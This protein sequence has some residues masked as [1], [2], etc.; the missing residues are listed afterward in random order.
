[1][2]NLLTG[3]TT[4]QSL[5]DLNFSQEFSKQ[6]F[7]HQ[8]SIDICC[9]IEGRGKIYNQTKIPT[10]VSWPEQWLVGPQQRILRDQRYQRRACIRA[11]VCWSC[12]S[13]KGGS[14]QTR[15]PNCTLVSFKSS[16]PVAC[17]SIPQ[18]RLPICKQI[19][20]H[21]SCQ[22][23]TRAYAKGLTFRSSTD[24]QKTHR[25]QVQKTLMFVICTETCPAKHWIASKWWY[26]VCDGHRHNLF[27]K[28]K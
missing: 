5:L 22:Q 19:I 18:H 7:S 20:Y 27:C 1:M 9:S 13:S 12:G 14:I 8:D 26:L 24:P 6:D 10:P 28:F 3:K 25:K 21:F 4:T 16:N 23:Q 17:L 15:C 2:I 11:E